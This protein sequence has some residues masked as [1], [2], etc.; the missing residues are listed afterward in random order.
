MDNLF[1][2]L[3]GCL[4]VWRISAIIVYEEGPFNIFGLL[5]KFKLFQCFACTSV[6]VALFVL[7]FYEI[8][9]E[10][11]MLF[12]LSTVPMLIEGIFFNVDD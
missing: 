5:R 2:F 12:A 3:I 1:E 9:P 11:F 4:A 8:V 6:W 10:L 7:L